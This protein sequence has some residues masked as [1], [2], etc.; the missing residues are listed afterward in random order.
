MS[1]HA[2]KT[3]LPITATDKKSYQTGVAAVIRGTAEATFPPCNP[4]R[5]EWDDWYW[6]GQGVSKARSAGLGP[7]KPPMSSEEIRRMAHNSN[8]KT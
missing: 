1:S 4:T 3:R 6:F 2:K 5:E 7:K 8:R